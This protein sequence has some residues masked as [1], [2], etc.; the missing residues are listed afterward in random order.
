MTRWAVV[1]AR[2]AV[3]EVMLE[4]LKRAELVEPPTCF[5]SARSAGA[6]VEFD[7][8]TLPVV[9]LDASSIGEFDVVLFSAGSAAAREWAPRFHAHGACVVDNSSAFR[10]DDDVALV[11]PEVNAA[12]IPEGPA[13][14]ANPNCSTII[15]LVAAAP[16]LQLGEFS[17]NV[18]TYQAVSGAGREGIVALRRELRGEDAPDSPFAAPI[19][20]N[21]IAQIGTPSDDERGETTEERKMRDESRKILGRPE[22]SVITTCVR[23]PVERCHSEAVTLT[24]D[25]EVSRADAIECLRGAPGVQ[26]QVDGDP[27]GPL[28]V[29]GRDDVFVSRVRQ[30]SSNVL[31]LWVVG[32]QLLKGAAL[33]AVQIAHAYLGATS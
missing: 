25:R 31:Q 4:C 2:G 28:D 32:D 17:A 24:F 13:I 30:P 19:A 12:A 15:F 22:L 6:T 29:A 1:G 26:L 23:V 16:L 10:L 27:P 33:N 3:G 9:P 8:N 7:G 11:V 14:V 21:L 20:N 18:A 5:G